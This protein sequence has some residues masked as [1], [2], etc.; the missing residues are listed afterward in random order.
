[1]HPAVESAVVIVGPCC[2][3]R[4]NECLTRREHLV[5]RSWSAGPRCNGVGSCI[6]VCPLYGVIDTNYDG[7]VLR[8]E[9][10]E[11]SRIS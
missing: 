9:S 7:D 4:V 3:E 8:R 10:N 6:V 2:C 1:M 5:K 11:G